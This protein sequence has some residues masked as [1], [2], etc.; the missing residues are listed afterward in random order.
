MTLEGRG[1]PIDMRVSKQFYSNIYYVEK[2]TF[3]NVQ[4]LAVLFKEQ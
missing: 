1:T 2:Q 4:E 3:D